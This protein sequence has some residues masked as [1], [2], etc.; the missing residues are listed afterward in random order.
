MKNI[1]V[2]LVSI[3]ALGT[4]SISAATLVYEGTTGPGK[5]RCDIRNG[6]SF[7]EIAGA[8]RRSENAVRRGRDWKVE[9]VWQE[10]E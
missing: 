6:H 8:M 5:G 3:V 7:A 1:L 9:K 10:R 2:T 4:T